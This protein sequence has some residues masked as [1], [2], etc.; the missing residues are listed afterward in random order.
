MR[1]PW[2]I[3]IA[4]MMG[5]GKTTLS[6]G[7]ARTFG[8]TYI[9]E[10]MPA[11]QYLT[12]LFNNPRRWAFET[13][14]AF[15]VHKATQILNN[16][17]IG[18]NIVVDRSLYEDANVFA[19]YFHS[20]GDI[21]DRSYETYRAL[22]SRFIQEAGPP[23][24]IVFCKCSK[25]TCEARISTRGRDFQKLYPP[26]HLAEIE[27][28]YSDWLSTYS[29]GAI[30][31]V[32]SEAVDWRRTDVVDMI[33]EEIESILERQRKS[34]SQLT[35][36]EAVEIDSEHEDRLLQPIFTFDD[37]SDAA[38]RSVIWNKGERTL[39][40]PTAYIA[41]PFTARAEFH[42][43]SDEQR[44]L[45]GFSKAHGRLNP[46]EY[47]SMLLG[48]E[49]ALRRYGISSLIPHRDINKW[50]DLSLSAKAVTD[51]CTKYVLKTDLFVGLLG[52]SHGSHYEFGLAHSLQKPSIIIRCDEIPS[53]FIAEGIN[54]SLGQVLVLECKRIRDIAKTLR[55]LDVQKFL[56]QYFEL[57]REGE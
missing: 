17:E 27:Q 48:V 43:A 22:A 3:A 36:F 56:S 28:L 46:G 41:A 51:L 25:L 23:D 24:L 14:L 13:Q 5:S 53:S 57:R 10:S 32:D 9:P 20:R 15:L 16:T 8:W 30:Y 2:V 4:G 21:D 55:S 37:S 54:E 29:E 47:R 40:Y 6:R 35:L 18:R 19:H 42:E 50:G 33:A 1:K 39:V 38:A 7:L 44:A 12:D 49:R 34:A 45:F 52:Q 11:V 26:N 31:S